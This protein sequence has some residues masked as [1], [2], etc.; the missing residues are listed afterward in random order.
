MNYKY[1]V[2]FLATFTVSCNGNHLKQEDKESNENGSVE[3]VSNLNSNDDSAL[4]ASQKRI[5]DA[6]KLDRFN[7]NQDSMFLRIFYPDITH[8]VVVEIRKTNLMWQ[9]ILFNIKTGYDTELGKYRVTLIDKKSKVPKSGWPVFVNDLHEL[10]VFTLPDSKQIP[11]YQQGIDG[12]SYTIEYA[13][14]DQHRY[15]RYWEPELN[16]KKHTEARRLIKFL[17]LIEK[18]FGFKRVQ[19][20]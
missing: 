6:I 5:A 1:C 7:D 4:T 8:S 3:N 16:Q 12:C 17:D 20:N 15:F 13:I 18:E 9:T 11:G 2:L 14:S 10:S 19:C